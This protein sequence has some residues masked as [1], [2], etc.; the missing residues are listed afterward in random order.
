VGFDPSRRIRRRRMTRRGDIIFVV[1]FAVLI[2]AVLLWAV[3]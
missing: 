2:A 1:G 3:L